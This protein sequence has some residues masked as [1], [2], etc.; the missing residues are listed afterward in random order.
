[1]NVHPWQLAFAID[2]DLWNKI[3]MIYDS[4]EIEHSKPLV[5]VR[6]RVKYRGATSSA[7]VP[8]G[9]VRYCITSKNLVPRCDGEVF[10]LYHDV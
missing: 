1:M 7:K 9:A 5:C 8:L 6:V 4:S 2:T 3:F 10:F